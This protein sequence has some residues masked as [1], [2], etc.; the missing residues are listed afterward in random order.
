M[1]G[2]ETTMKDFKYKFTQ[3]MAAALLSYPG[4]RIESHYD[5][6]VFRASPPPVPGC[7]VAVL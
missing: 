7:E 4:A 3:D 5:G 1:F 2:G 6:H